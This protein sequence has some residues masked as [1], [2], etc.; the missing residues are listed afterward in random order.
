MEDKVKDFVAGWLKGER[1]QIG[2]EERRERSRG[3]VLRV[4]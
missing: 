3:H 4:L 1:W 2:A